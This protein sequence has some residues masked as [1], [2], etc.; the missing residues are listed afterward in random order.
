MVRAAAAVLIGLA[1]LTLVNVADAQV[2]ARPTW[3][4][5]AS[6]GSREVRRLSMAPAMDPV[7]REAEEVGCWGGTPSAVSGLTCMHPLLAPG[8]GSDDDAFRVR[9][10]IDAN[11]LLRQG[12]AGL[13]G[14]LAGALVL[15]L[16]FAIAERGGQDVSD[17]VTAVAATIGYM[18]GSV[19][20]VQYYSQ[21]QGM[22]SSWWGT[23]GGAVL[24]GLGGPLFLVTVPTGAVVGFNFTPAGLLP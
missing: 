12:I 24:G 22:T 11:M 5:T 15:V 23:L 8:F 20:G 18:G 3:S 17:D 9:R 4:L 16:P 19:V 6:T 2:A 1:S 21:R 10:R 7:V 14:G 13:A